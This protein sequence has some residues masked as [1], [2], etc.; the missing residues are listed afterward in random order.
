MLRLASRLSAPLTLQIQQGIVVR[1][2]PK[3]SV[4]D[5]TTYNEEWI[6]R[7]RLYN[8][9]R[10]PRQPEWDDPNYLYPKLIPPLY[11][12]CSFKH[13]VRTVI[14]EEEKEK[15][16]RS[17]EYLLTDIRPGDI[18]DISYQETFESDQVVT[19]RGLVLSFKR[20][21]SWT[22]ALELAIRFGGMSLKCIYLVHSPKVKKV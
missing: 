18:V 16:L 17:K 13:Y 7:E 8:K 6:P 3:R 15:A 12:P 20:R 11:K 19:H 21:N 9:H 5:K 1:Y 2:T 22:A 14:E 10:K 4:F